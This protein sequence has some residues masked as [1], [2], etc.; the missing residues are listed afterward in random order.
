MSAKRWIFLVGLLLAACQSAP[1]PVAVPTP[2][3]WNLAVTSSV[4]WLAPDFNQCMLSLPERAIHL[5]EMPAARLLENSPDVAF[6]WGAPAEL[7]SPAYELGL[8]RLAVIVNAQN[9]IRR[10]NQVNLQGIFNG[11]SATWAEVFPKDCPDCLNL[12]EGEIEAWVYPTGED[13]QTNFEEVFPGASPLS[14]AAFLAS[15]PADVIAAVAA[16]PSAIGFVPAAWLQD[17]N[18]S[19]AEIEVTGI[20]VGSLERPYLAITTHQPGE[21]LSAWL[22]CLQQSISLPSSK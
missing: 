9:P 13:I 5:A 15:S 3:V 4:T 20:P 17:P 7:Q 18:P 19:L 14:S 8:D 21:D 6:R 2:Q 22:T 12:P 11:T 16:S 1:P 10:L